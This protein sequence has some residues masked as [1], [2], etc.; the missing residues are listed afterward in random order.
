MMAVCQRELIK[1]W[2]IPK[3]VDLEQVEQCNLQSTIGIWKENYVLIS[4]SDTNK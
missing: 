4:H 1:E 2:R 3:W